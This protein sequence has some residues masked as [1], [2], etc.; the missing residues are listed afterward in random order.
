M[1]FSWLWQLCANSYF[2][3][4]V[5]AIGAIWLYRSFV[6]P[7][8]F[9]KRLGVPTPPAYPIVGTLLA[10]ME[11]DTAN[12]QLQ[13]I[14]IKKYGSVYGMFLGSRPAY[15]VADLDMIKQILIKDFSKCPNRAAM[16]NIPQ[17][18]EGIVTLRDERWKH[19]RTI[20]NPTFTTSKMKHMLPIM[21]DSIHILLKKME[22]IVD[23][24]QSIDIAE[25]LKLLSMEIIAASAFG[26]KCD[27]QS[28]AND[29]LLQ[30]ASAIFHPS[31]FSVF[32]CFMIPSLGKLAMT[33]DRSFTNGYNYVVNV[34]KSIIRERNQQGVTEANYKD[35]LQLM[36][37]ANRNSTGKGL[38]DDEIVAQASAFM[39]AGYET[40]SSCLAFTA[41]LLAI[42]PAIQEQ[43]RQEIND[44]CND[45]EDITYE[46]IS[47]MTYLDMVIN[48]SL[49]IFPP[50]YILIREA[51]VDFQCNGYTFPKGVPIYIPVY[52]THHNPEIWPEPEKFD[53]QRFTK[54]AVEARHSCAF[55]PFGIGPRSCIGMRFAL[56]EVKL[57][58][59]KILRR[60]KFLTSPETEVPLQ[61]TGITNLAPKNGIRLR[62]SSN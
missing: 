14:Q 11:K 20:L 35:L 47:K 36:I 48:E 39:L 42:N 56:V 31:A 25:W 10:D 27:A 54:E 49:R 16:L 21:T 29:R 45:E 58:L 1:Q 53:P 41:Y 4:S 19:V 60:F 59:A 13:Q 32:V 44:I 52:A 26:T 17:K 55:M 28:G 40:T 12:H 23:T 37:D 43:L 5:I 33:M 2:W 18:E 22:K 34:V 6:A 30:S 24:D 9:F 46:M 8:Q 3:Y 38:T 15:M 7:L 62:V 51:K 61:L 57:S 50:G